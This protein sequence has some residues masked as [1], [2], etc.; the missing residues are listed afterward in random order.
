VHVRWDRALPVAAVAV[1]W[2]LA[3]LAWSWLKE[4][5]SL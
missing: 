2:A 4:M 3:A 5:R 1:F